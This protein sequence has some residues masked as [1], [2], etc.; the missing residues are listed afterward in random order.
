[1]ESLESTSI[2]K[3]IK[4]KRSKQIVT[5]LQDRKRVKIWQDVD[6]KTN[7]IKGLATRTIQNFPQYFVGGINEANIKKANRWYKGS[8]T[9][10]LLEEKNITL[11]RNGHRVSRKTLSGRGRKE[12]SWS[13]SISDSVLSNFERYRAAGIKITKENIRII[14]LSELEKVEELGK[15][16]RNGKKFEEFIDKNWVNR[17]MKKN[18]I[19]LR[20]QEG[21]LQVSKEK[22][23][24]FKNQYYHS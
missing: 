24:K 19:V 18:N 10:K 16:S 6:Q 7:S 13:K 4:R 23:K 8:N 14:A 11:S 21:K 12:E 9:Q 1:M 20:G 22:E 15:I 17:F 5:S 3:P 2:I